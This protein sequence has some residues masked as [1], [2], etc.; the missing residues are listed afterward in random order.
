V[1][2]CH[3]ATP[4]RRVSTLSSADTLGR[5]GLP[6][7]R[8]EISEQTN[9]RSMYES[10][11]K[12]FYLCLDEI[13]VVLGGCG[14][15][16]QVPRSSV[17]GS[18]IYSVWCQ[19]IVAKT[20][21]RR[22]SHPYDAARMKMTARHP[23]PAGTLAQQKTLECWTADRMDTMNRKSIAYVAE[24]QRHSRDSPLHRRLYTTRSRNIQ[25]KF[26]A[27]DEPNKR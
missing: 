6:K 25:R 4:H 3:A 26:D 10:K 23:L 19:S 1:R 9:E 2:S 18:W 15:Y 8:N 24:I 21:S 13:L 22:P 7:N 27:M 17:S 14:L 16:V 11:R 5:K 20:L 12:P